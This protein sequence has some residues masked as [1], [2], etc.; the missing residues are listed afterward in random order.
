MSRK[1]HLDPFLFL[2]PPPSP[3]RYAREP[4]GRVFIQMTGTGLGTR[5]GWGG[6]TSRPRE[7]GAKASPPWFCLFLSC[8][9]PVGPIHK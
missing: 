3:D 7:G 1:S 8:P 5:D 6:K 4:T 9:S 2:F